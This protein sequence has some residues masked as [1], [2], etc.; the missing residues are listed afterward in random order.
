VAANP[1]QLPEGF[2]DELSDAELLQATRGLIGAMRA[3]Y[4]AGVG[5]WLPELQLALLTLATTDRSRRQLVTAGRIAWLS[6]VVSLAAV[7]VAA[8]R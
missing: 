1:Y 8:L 2:P 7:L 5:E 3:R 4:G 6:L